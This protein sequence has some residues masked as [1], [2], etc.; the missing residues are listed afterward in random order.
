MTVTIS[1]LLFSCKKNIKNQNLFYLNHSDTVD[2]V[3]IEAC[4]KCHIDKYV[5]FMQTG[6]GQSFNFATKQKSI[7]DFGSNHVVFDSVNNFYYTPFWNNDELFIK[8]FRLENNDTIYS[9][10][11]K[12]DYIIGS[13]QHTNSHLMLRKGYIFQAPL[14]WYSQKRKWDLPPGFEKG[15]NSRFSRIVNDECIS[16]HNALPKT[17]TG[18]ENKFI[19]IGEGIDCERCH[20]PGELHVNIHT[21]GKSIKSKNGIDR[22]IVNPS[23]LNREQ[24]IDVCQRCHLQGNSILK[25]GKNFTGFKPGMILSDFYEVYMPEFENSETEF[26]MASHVQRLKKSKCFTKSNLTCITC[27]N[28]HISVKITKTEVFNNTCKNCHETRG[29][30]SENPNLLRTQNN[31]CIKCHMP[32]SGTSDIPHV[33]I[34]DHF[35]RKKI[36][37]S[38]SN[39]E[40]KIKGLYCVNNP[41]PDDKNLIKAYLNY[42]EKFDAN[43]IYLKNAK[44]ILDKK[45]DL[46]SEIH[47]FY[48]KGDYKNVVKIALKLDKNEP[49]VEWTAYRIGQSYMNLGQWQNAEY[50]IQK[51]SDLQPSNFEFLYKLSQVKQNLKKSASQE[52]LLKKVIALNPNHTQ[53]LSDLGFYYFANGNSSLAYSFYKQSYNTNPDFLP[54]LK[55]LFDYYISQ[56]NKQKAKETA[57][58]ILR[59]EPKNEVLIKFLKSEI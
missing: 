2:Y 36:T 9:Q 43:E 13:G 41:K 44:K 37:K 12:I 28:P 29:K 38:E 32:S 20:G 52:E 51:A 54:V 58:A 16:C 31:N 30:C 57:K 26:I 53:A 59:K 18:S 56:N 34:H 27:H 35:I 3:G 46:A 33:Q 15:N 40:R 22:T 48:L 25:D 8:E 21:R 42:Y 11:Q 19:K 14:T 47:Y 39:A 5:S 7:A 50:F 23:K 55:N 17:E 24:Q 6:M 10:T 4:K 1:A 45:S 49:T